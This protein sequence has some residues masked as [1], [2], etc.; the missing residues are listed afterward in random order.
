MRLLNIYCTRYGRAKNSFA[1]RSNQTHETERQSLRR[2][3]HQNQ[4]SKEQHLVD[5][6]MGNSSPLL[7]NSAVLY[8]LL[9]LIDIFKAF[10]A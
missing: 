1:T 9:F 8:R 3:S 10:D 4:S 2:A 7:S 5:R 6:L